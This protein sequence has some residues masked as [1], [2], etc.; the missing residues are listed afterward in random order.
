MDTFKLR[1]DPNAIYYWAA[2]NTMEIN[3][4]KFKHIKYAKDEVVGKRSRYLSSDGKL[5]QDKPYVKDL[6]VKMSSD[7][8]FK[9]H[10]QK[11]VNIVGFWGRF[12]QG[13]LK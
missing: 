1:R 3:D 6:G 5:I 13:L 2:K 8:T 12:P 11:V 9:Q 7:C 10:I 4:C